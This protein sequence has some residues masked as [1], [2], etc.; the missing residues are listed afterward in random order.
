MAM[1]AGLE[2]SSHGREAA[3]PK[4]TF[5]KLL[6]QALGEAQWLNL[7][8]SIATRFGPP[9]AGAR[10][11]RFTGTVHWAYCSLL[12]AVLGHAIRGLAVLPC[13]VR[14]N[15]DFLFLIEHTPQGIVKE[16]TY[17]WNDG[18]RFV[19]KSR[20]DDVPSLHEE[21]RAGFGMYLKL[22]T[23]QGALL[24]SDDGFFLRFGD[25]RLRLPRR[26]FAA[27]FALLHRSIDSRR[28]QV[29]IRVSHPILG[30]LFYQRGEFRDD[31]SHLP[32][33]ATFCEF[34]D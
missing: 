31:V 16:R 6:R 28:F 33:A 34:A 8:A 32:P 27:R 21:F 12:G 25:I 5:G 9:A 30:T 1:Q 2:H 3:Q 20:F 29:L 24:F 22:S 18:A 19:F 7:D 14:R 4:K 15:A 13:Q 26:L 11:L 17:Y 10:N 23:E